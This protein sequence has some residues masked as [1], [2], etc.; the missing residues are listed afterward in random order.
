MKSFPFLLGLVLAWR[1]AGLA[2]DPAPIPPIERRLP[3]PGI[4]IPADVKAGFW[5][6]RMAIGRIAKEGRKYGAYLGIITQRPSELDQTI[7]SQCNTFFAMR[8]SNTKDQDIIA[9]AF[10]SGAQSTIAF[11]PSISN[12]ECIAFGEAVYS[13]MRMTFETVG[14]EDLPGAHIRE[15]QNA[16]RAGRE[17]NLGAIISRMRGTNIPA[18]LAHGDDPYGHDLQALNAASM[19][20]AAAKGGGSG[21][22]PGTAAGNAARM[23]DP[24]KID[25]L[26]ALANKS[27]E[28]RYIDAA[29]DPNG[30]PG[31]P[32]PLRNNRENGNSLI[33]RLRG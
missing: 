13:P 25:A 4:E 11:L 12:R 18:S 2:A 7:L 10:N 31:T 20:Q 3:P 1:V 21:A 27:I 5:P 19:S 22:A 28:Q 26:E 24:A 33:R 14:A 30:P 9:G 32:E 15:N 23:P 29:K 6:T 8:L 16:V 17:I